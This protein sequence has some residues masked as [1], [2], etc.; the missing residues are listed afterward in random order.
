MILT[1]FVDLYTKN[2]AVAIP[3]LDSL[4]EE[5]FVACLGDIEADTVTRRDGGPLPDNVPTQVIRPATFPR[6]EVFLF[7][8]SI[9]IIDFGE[10][11]FGHNPPPNLQTAVAIRPPEVLFNDR[12]DCRVDLWSGGCLVSTH[13]KFQSVD[14]NGRGFLNS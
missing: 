1:P 9:K 3:G 12:V 11:F 5:D 6:R 14:T 4:S 13:R 10:S 7:C 2:V 8:P